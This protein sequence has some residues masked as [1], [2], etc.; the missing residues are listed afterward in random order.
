VG[1]ELGWRVCGLGM[2]VEGVLM[3]RLNGILAH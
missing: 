1:W 3:S 2:R